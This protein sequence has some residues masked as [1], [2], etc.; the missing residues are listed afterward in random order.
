MTD[1]EPVS[2][3]PVA[4]GADTV[5]SWST[6]VGLLEKSQA[7]YWLAT[8]RPNGSPHVMPQGSGEGARSSQ[9]RPRQEGGRHA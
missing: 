1:R 2:A 5:T 8:V 3:E 6:A 9:V 7:T 4:G